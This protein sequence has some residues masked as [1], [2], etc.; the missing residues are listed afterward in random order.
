VTPACAKERWI[1]LRARTPILLAVLLMLPVAPAAGRWASIPTDE[2]IADSDLIVVG[3][4]EETTEYTRGDRSFGRG[5]IVV[6][7]VLWGRAREGD[8]LPLRWSNASTISCPRV[9]HAGSAGRRIIWLLERGRGGTVRADHPG[10]VLPLLEQDE[11][12]DLVARSPLRLPRHRVAQAGSRL[13]A[14][15]SYRNAGA[16]PR[17]FPAV[18]EQQGRIEIGSGLRLRVLR[19][20]EQRRET[21]L[22]PR[23]EEVHVVEH[24]RVTAAPGEEIPSRIDLT[25]AFGLSAPGSYRIE[26]GLPGMTKLPRMELLVLDPDEHASYTAAERAEELEEQRYD[27]VKK[28]SKVMPLLSPVILFLVPLPWLVRAAERHRRRRT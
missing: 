2:L 26:V 5:T 6:E 12:T 28:S 1:V 19:Q 7:R 25:R 23:R 10:R 4:L 22:A 11:V 20:D 9:E 18:R 3:A 24:A 21:A 8:R 13:V 16:V 15:F 27:G 17:A 14:E